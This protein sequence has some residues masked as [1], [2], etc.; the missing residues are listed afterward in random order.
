M[1]IRKCKIDVERDSL[2]P[3]QEPEYSIRIMPKKRYG[4]WILMLQ[5]NETIIEIAS[6]EGNQLANRATN[7]TC[8]LKKKRIT[9]TATVWIL[10]IDTATYAFFDK[11]NAIHMAAQMQV[12][13]YNLYE[14]QL[15]DGQ[16]EP[17][18]YGQAIIYAGLQFK[19]DGK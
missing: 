19:K 10:E 18:N 15:Y 9:M 12:R 13:D 7:K 6:G 1:K 3:P 4:A 11:E 5:W 14:V 2:L 8:D 17:D 16:V